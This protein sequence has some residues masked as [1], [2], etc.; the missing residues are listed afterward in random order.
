MVE[1][2]TNIWNWLL[3]NK[4]EIIMFFTSSNFVAFISTIILLI[5]QL[6]SNDSI[7]VTNNKLNTS[8]AAS[9]K[10]VTDLADAKNTVTAIDGR[11]NTLNDE[12]SAFQEVLNNLVTK[13]D[14]IVEVQSIVY[15][16]IKDE[17]IRNNV[18]GILLDAKHTGS[19]KLVE[20]QEELEHLKEKL[21]EKV[22]DVAEVVENTAEKVKQTVSASKK[23]T[24]KRY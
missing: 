20:L 24:T 17:T 16:T 9:T 2:F 5:K 3:D 1:F 22:N 7:K 10:A 8:I 11:L 15:S 4:D 19:K 18:K 14:A 12:V 6:K 13:M 21:S 23:S